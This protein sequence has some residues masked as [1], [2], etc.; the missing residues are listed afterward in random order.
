MNTMIE[1]RNQPVNIYKSINLMLETE[2]YGLCHVAH[3]LRLSLCERGSKSH[4]NGLPRSFQRMHLRPRGQA[5]VNH[6]T[7]TS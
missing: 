5:L 4:L 3:S 6:E 1:I 2:E 7:S